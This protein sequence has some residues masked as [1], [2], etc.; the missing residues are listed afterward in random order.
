MSR[1]CAK[2]SR[3]CRADG[4]TLKVHFHTASDIDNELLLHLRE[5]QIIIFIG[6]A[7]NNFGLDELL[8]LDLQRDV[9]VHVVD[10]ALEQLNDAEEARHHT[11]VEIVVSSS[12][13]STQRLLD[14]VLVAFHTPPDR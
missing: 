2:A 7:I 11:C 6:H 5:D 3:R 12:T 1:T 10:A 13:P 9:V 8:A 14:S 4:G